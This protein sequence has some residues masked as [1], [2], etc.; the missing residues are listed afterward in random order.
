MERS[1]AAVSLGGGLQEKL[2]AIASA[3][4]TLVE[5]TES[6]LLLSDMRPGEIRQL[7]DE[8]G[9]CVS[10]FHAMSDIEA[11]PEEE[12]HRALQRVERKFELM[13]ELGA[14]LLLVSASTSPDAIDDDELAAQHL[15]ELAAKAADYGIRIGYSASASAR[16]VRRISQAWNIVRCADHPG[17]GLVLDS[18]E[19][20]VGGGDVGMV[21]AIPGEKIFM[22]QLADAP[23]LHIDAIT[24]GRHFRSF[25]GQGVL[26]VAGF[27]AATVD[28]GYQGA[29]SLEVLNDEVRAA[30]VRQSALDA[31]RSLT[32]VEEQI[33]Y[34]GRKL[35]NSTFAASAPPALPGDESIGFIEFAVNASSRLELGQW[36]Q[37]LGFA[38]A[39][40]HRSKDVDLYRQGDVLI[41][42]NAG[43]DT[44]AHYY[45]HLHG[46]SVCATGMHVSNPADI[47]ER[48]ALYQYKH[49]Q[50]RRGPQ[51]YEMP[52]VRSP[53]GSLIHLLGDD[54]SPAQD[55][56]L[57][58]SGMVSAVGIKRVDHMARAVPPGQMGAWILFYRSILGLVP[59][60]SLNIADP[61]G[62]V[63][64]TALRDR[65][66]QLR[67]PL[68][69][70]DNSATVVARALTNFG[71][72]GVNQIA[73]ETD[74][75]FASVT[76][77]RRNGMD[78][79]RIPAN[80]YRR[81]EEDREV[82]QSLVRKL[83]D[84][85]ILYDADGKGGE[86]FHAYTDF[87]GGRFFFEV[88]Q[89]SGGYDRYGEVNSPVRLAVQARHKLRNPHE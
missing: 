30:P 78:L 61:H 17:I 82:S 37:S 22:V 65:S 41:V 48:A 76:A 13:K 70:S 16:H 43:R 15:R 53:D 69:C 8:I 18:F 36:L 83:E 45:H 57:H 23:S 77:I 35:R 75:I 9:L 29:Y 44:F 26:D 49:Y 50:E 3:G 89:R 79:L 52:A 6:D 28:T 67:L 10:A 40:R 32:F 73:F 81:L 20:L 4:F 60:K 47:L 84:A 59:E 68:T 64:S 34:T 12:F 24:L 62:T 56:V 31:M 27:V 25:P 80:Y 42:L 46:I 58:E 51:E 71:G 14:P 2:Y 39:G 54:Y 86:F 55:F 19:V 11:V 63:S 88:V 21:A 38:S 72:A 66:N 85:N 5:L 7:L 74:D 87:F 1:I 33:Y